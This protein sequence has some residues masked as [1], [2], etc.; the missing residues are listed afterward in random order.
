VHPGSSHDGDWGGDAR[1]QAVVLRCAV[2]RAGGGGGLWWP[3]PM[4]EAMCM[5]VWSPC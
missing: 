1:M 4:M 5:H 3:E 2:D